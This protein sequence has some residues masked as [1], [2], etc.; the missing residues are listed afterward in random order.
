M[1]IGCPYC[2]ERWN[3][4]FV[5]LGD[6]DA[7]MKHPAE[8]TFA[9]FYD[10]VYLRDNPAGRHRELWYHQGGCRQWLVV[11]RDTLTHAVHGVETARCAAQD[12]E[13]A[14]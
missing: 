5:V 1:R 6:A 2:G 10:Y 8:A 3:D 13:A 9:L 14:S 11:T 7:M 4:E 12:I